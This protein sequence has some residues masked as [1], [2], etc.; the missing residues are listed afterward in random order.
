MNS[1]RLVLAFLVM[2]M[3]AVALAAAPVKVAFVDGTVHVLSGGAWKPL[4]FD[5]EFDSAQSVR[6]GPGAI[7]ELS[8]KSGSSVTISAAGTYVVDALLKPRTEPSAVSTVAAKLEK[9]AKGGTGSGSVAGVRGAAADSAG[10]LMWSDAGVDA[11]AAFQEA[12]DAMSAGTYSIA[13]DL[14]MQAISLYD[15][16]EDPTGA[17]RS[18]WH[19]SLAGLAAGSGARALAALRSASP[20]DAGALRAS[21]ALALATL[22]ARYGAAAEAKVLLERAIKAGWFDDPTM[23]SDAK[24]LLS[25]L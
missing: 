14:F 11:E 17:S 4:D 13:W 23:A 15:E 1:K 19:A 3:C 9:L 10:G 16:A 20:D 7:L 21:Y 24:T 22:N 25:S 2:V 5:D 12:Q 18:A 6:L 8:V